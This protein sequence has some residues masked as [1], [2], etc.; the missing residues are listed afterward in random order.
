MKKLRPPHSILT[1]FTQGYVCGRSDKHKKA[2][3]EPGTHTPPTPTKRLFFSISPF[4]IIT[5]PMWPTTA[6]VSFD[7]NFSRNEMVE[8][9]WIDAIWRVSYNGKCRQGRVSRWW[10]STKF[11]CSGYIFGHSLLW[12]SWLKQKKVYMPNALQNM[13]KKSRSDHSSEISG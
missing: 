3:W 8:N 4:S 7:F 6:R 12:S 5:R 2:R 11:R 13:L 1:W 9:P 10:K